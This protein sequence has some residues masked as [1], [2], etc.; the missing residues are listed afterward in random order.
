ML[1]VFSKMRDRVYIKVWDSLHTQYAEYHRNIAQALCKTIQLMGGIP[2]KTKFKLLD[3]KIPLAQRKG[4]CTCGFHVLTRIW[5]ESTGQ[6]GRKIT[7]G[8]I[9]TVR[10]YVQ[11]MILSKKIGNVKQEDSSEEEYE[12]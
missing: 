11:F 2:H 6:I 4:F 12:M 1:V 3:P 10:R 9:E 7:W 8:T 5:M